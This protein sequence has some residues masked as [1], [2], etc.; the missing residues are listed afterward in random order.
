M[1]LEYNDHIQTIELRNYNTSIKYK[2]RPYH[3]DQEIDKNSLMGKV[4]VCIYE[5]K[6]KTMG[7]NKRHANKKKA[8]VLPMNRII[9]KIGMFLKARKNQA[10]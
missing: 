9:K 6:N 4:E 1:N 10:M 2:T 3:D 5:S 8:S 7:S